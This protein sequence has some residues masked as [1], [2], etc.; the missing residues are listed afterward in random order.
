MP[1]NFNEFIKSKGGKK[2]LRYTL[3]EVLVL[4]AMLWL[5]SIL[6]GRALP[7]IAI[8]QIAELTNT[9]IETSLVD[10]N[11]DGSVL[12]ENLEVRPDQTQVYDDAI[13]KAKRV[14]ARFSI[15]SLLML[16]PRLK[17]ININDFI[18]NAI[19][20]LDANR[21]N[22]TALKI[23]DPK[24]GSGKMPIIQLNRGTLKYSKVLDG[25][26]KTAVAIP[27]NATLGP[28][29]EHKG[30]YRFDITTAKMLGGFGKS[31]LIGF[32]QPGLL[33]ITGGVSSEDTPTFERA[34]TI[35]ILAAEFKY[36][37]NRDY[38][39]ELKVKDFISTHRL[40]SDT[41]A[42]AKPTFLEK[43]GLFG[44]LQ[45]SFERYRP[46]GRIDIKLSA[47]GNFDQLSKSRLA[48]NVHCK[49]VSIIYQ[50][51]PYTTEH[52]AG[53]IDFTE[54]SIILNNISGY[55]NDVKLFLNGWAK[56][57]GP[58]WEYQI[59]VTSDN[60]ILDDDFYNALKPKYQKN[61]RN[62]SPSG[63]V[64]IDYRSNRSAQGGKRNTL[65]IRPLGT[66]ASYHHFPYPLKNLS[67][68]IF[69]DHNVITLSDVT[70]E[71]DNRKIVLNGKVLTGGDGTTYDIKIDAKDLP[72]DSKLVASLP[73]KQR[74]FWSRLDTA[75]S[76][77]G[78]L[79]GRIWSAKENRKLRYHLSLDTGQMELTDKLLSILPESAG[80]I[81]S[82]LQPKGEVNVAVDLDKTNDGKPD[83]SI[84]VT[85]LGNSINFEKF[86]YP[87]RDISGDL[88]IDKDNIKLRDI[89]ATAADNIQVTASGPT[90]KVNG[91]VTLADN[92]FSKG[93]FRLLVNDV[94]LD[95]RLGIALPERMRDY[96]SG[97]YPTGRFD[98]DF[99]SIKIF[100]DVNN[101]KCVDFD[102]DIILKGCGFGSFPAI[103]EL[104]ATLKTKGLYNI[105]NGFHNSQIALFADKFRIMG[106]SL[107]AVKADIRYD[108]NQQNWLTKNLTADC[109]QGNATGKFELRVHDEASFEYILQAG[110]D[111]IDLKE[112]LADTKTQKTIEND[113]SS[114]QLNGSLSI[115]G[116]IGDSDSRIGRCRLKI[117]DMQV[118]KL[119]LVAKL[120]RVLNMTKPTDFAF[121]Q[122]L[123][124]S[125]IKHNKLFV[126]KVD[127]SGK[128]L[129]F[130]GSGWVDLQN[131]KIDLSLTARSH[132]RLASD[133][134]SV[135]GSLTEGLGHAVVRLDVTGS[136]YE[137]EVKTKTLPVIKETLELIG[138]RPDAPSQP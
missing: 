137:P 93:E 113:Y 85:C 126:R 23:G 78:D 34:W 105:N 32:W 62:F 94:F 36:E 56:N 60:M 17:V 110:F 122:M 77:S 89:T 28:A 52:L 25:Q 45:K 33:T 35:D 43:F 51:F 5:F 19:Q 79:T 135:L 61:W 11:F 58:D 130:N 123:V 75:G 109:Y 102:G 1:I 107:K 121:K 97:L 116:W 24:G 124:D 49:D 84:I 29:K 41:L 98:L 129:A 127:L 4:A 138:T 118:G 8:A 125:Y 136:F 72:L 73:E 103:T 10:F 69:F 55:H 38:L 46:S 111:N 59:Q 100:N 87:L 63:L 131:Q 3:P 9:K 90:I 70:S 18:F 83:Y 117:T 53:R 13:L 96:Y 82:N 68:E 54:E 108:R 15:G 57:F 7:R 2:I 6:A 104:E 67:G 128:S 112:F 21:W 80:K 106:K 48:G 86:A 132:R 114:G 133:E 16:R 64:A 37:P 71:V 42:F 44:V 76:L 120:L 39:I 101:G 74:Q 26:I 134:P 50:K 22:L 119:S 27:L 30:I 91:Q 20:D 31:N 40:T 95:E 14:Y 115:S 66:A 12:I 65:M 88:I 92:A 99:E 47:S 81:I